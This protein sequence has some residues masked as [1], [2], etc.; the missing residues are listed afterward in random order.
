MKY[1]L[2]IDYK[3]YFIFI[4]T[5]IIIIYINLNI[6]FNIQLNDNYL[7]IQQQIKLKFNNTIKNKINL[8]IYGYCLINGGRARITSLLI[9]YLYNIK[10]FKIY[11]FTVEDKQLNEYKIPQDI[12]RA[13]VKNNLIKLISKYKIDIIIYQLDDLKEIEILNN[14]EKVNVI[15]YH[16]SSNFDWIYSNFIMYK[17]IYRLFKLSKYIVSIVPFEND[18]LF[19]KWGINSIKIDNFITYKYNLI[20][21]SDLSSNII[22]MLGRGQAKKKRF[23]IGI[24]SMEY[25]IKYIPKAQLKIISDLTGISHLLNLII[26]LKLEN[27]INFFGYNTNPEIYFK[28]ASLNIF[29][30]ISEAF[31]M[32][33]IETKEYGIPNILIG[34]DYIAM[35]KKGNIIIYDD[36]PELLAREAIKILKY[37]N[38]K[39]NLGINARRSISKYNNKMLLMKWI[40]IILSVFNGYKYYQQLK[41][42]NKEINKLDALN[43]IKNQ[44]SLLKKRIHF[45]NNITIKNYENFTY[46]ENQTNF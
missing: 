32:V 9:N 45:F 23:K 31:P 37:K 44:I 41:Y 17:S 42:N 38:Y 20:I 46:M 4:L 13:V 40:K 12:K 25:I 3:L 43:I 6:K 7:N 19:K 24:Q 35:A 22:I 28:N 34:L 21:P 33:I 39:K 18:Y 29:P 5:F 26:N 8:S 27:N 15:F 14:I 10:I 11:L 30:S 2:I 1:E 36:L 16:H